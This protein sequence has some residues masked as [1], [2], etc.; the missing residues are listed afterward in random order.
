MLIRKKPLN[1]SEWSDY[2]T[3]QSSSPEPEMDDVTL[4][5]AKNL[6]RPHHAARDNSRKF[7]FDDTVAVVK[8]RNFIKLKNIVDR[9]NVDYSHTIFQI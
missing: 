9:F 1:E 8:T 7:Y 3:D 2:F 6:D 4:V 5:P